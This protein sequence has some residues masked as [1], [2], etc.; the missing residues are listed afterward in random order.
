[1]ALE[2]MKLH[3]CHAAVVDILMPDRDG[4]NFILEVRRTRPDLRIVAISGGG[5]LGAGPLLS[6]ADGLGADAVLAKPFSPSELEIA[7]ISNQTG[8]KPEKR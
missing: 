1:M 8:S 4:L 6:M 3:H 5:R 2:L 7:L